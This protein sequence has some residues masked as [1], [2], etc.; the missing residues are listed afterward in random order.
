MKPGLF[1]KIMDQ[2]KAFANQTCLASK[3]HVLVLLNSEQDDEIDD[4]GRLQD[5]TS[6]KGECCYNGQSGCLSLT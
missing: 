5:L 4:C 6:D 1:A 3:R 2:A